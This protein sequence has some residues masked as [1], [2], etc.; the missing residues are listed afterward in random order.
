MTKQNEWY[1]TARKIVRLHIGRILGQAATMRQKGKNALQMRL[2]AGEKQS[3]KLRADAIIPVLTYVLVLKLASMPGTVSPFCWEESI[4]VHPPPID[5]LEGRGCY[6]GSI[7][8][9]G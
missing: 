1:S 6:R 5:H 8:G 7:L 2:R 3:R 4:P 9:R